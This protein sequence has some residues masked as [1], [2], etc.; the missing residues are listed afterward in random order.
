M[1]KI[2]SIHTRL[3]KVDV[4]L[5]KIESR[6]DNLVSKNNLKEQTIKNE[7]SRNAVIK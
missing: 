7:S 4:R 3:D 2:K 5:D 6:L 1:L